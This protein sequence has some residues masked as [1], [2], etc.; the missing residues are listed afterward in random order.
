[1]AAHSVPRARVAMVTGASS[2]I[3][4]A[5][6]CS[7]GALGWPVAI[8]ARRTDR[9]AQT[10]Q[11]LEAAGG[12]ALAL[13]LDVTRA[14]SVESFF[15]AVERE[16]GPVSVVVSNAAV[17]RYGPLDDFSPEEIEREVATKLLGG[18][19]VARRA[20]RTMRGL[21]Q[22]CDIVFLTSIAAQMPWPLHLPYAAAN[23]GL[24][25]AA[26]MLKLELE[27]TGIRVGAL[28]CGE[29][30]GTEF[31]AGEAGLARQREA[32]EFWYRRGLLRHHGML[33]PR[34]VAA[35]VQAMVTLPA[36]VQYELLA[37]VPVAPRGPQPATFGEF[38]AG[39]GLPDAG[40]DGA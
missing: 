11:M 28:R 8:G 33:D 17:G 39:F 36:G 40:G 34:D 10:A 26:R 16:L 14:D 38:A 7:L 21:D 23:A 2:G 30:A 27:G 15:T 5:I 32:I 24:E 22:V 37:A 6:A 35:A 25:H 18:L 20:I 4:R 13:P 31:G 1:M 9:L 3:G 19:Y 29:T 12:R